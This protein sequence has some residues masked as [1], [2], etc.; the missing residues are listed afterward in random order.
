MDKATI[1]I[2]MPKKL[3][4]AMDTAAWRLRIRTAEFVRQAVQEK[5]DKKEVVE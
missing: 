3:K 5:I 4:T 1:T 2:E